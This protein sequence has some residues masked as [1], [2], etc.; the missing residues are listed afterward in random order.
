MDRIERISKAISFALQEMFLIECRWDEIADALLLQSS[1]HVETAI[2]NGHAY[3]QSEMPW[4]RLLE[5]ISVLLV[6]KGD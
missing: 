5:T 6:G 1:G 3:L 4:K 2:R